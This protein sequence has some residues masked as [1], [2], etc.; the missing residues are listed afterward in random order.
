MVDITEESM[1]D[2]EPSW[3]HREVRIVSNMVD[4]TDPISEGM[5]QS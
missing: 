2:R 4:I 5:M 3:R 1:I